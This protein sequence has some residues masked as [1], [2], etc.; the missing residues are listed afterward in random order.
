L[1]AQFGCQPA[2]F[3]QDPIGDIECIG[4]RPGTVS[5]GTVHGADA[6]AL[7]AQRDLATQQNS[8]LRA[9][10][11]YRRSLVDFERVQQ[12]PAAGRGTTITTVSGN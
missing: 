11:D 6:V 8:E 2:S 3:D 7:Q 10:L 9:L 1:P 4:L 12:S 5:A